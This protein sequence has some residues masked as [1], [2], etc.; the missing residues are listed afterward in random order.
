MIEKLL[1]GLSED[2]VTVLVNALAFEAD[3]ETPYTEGQV[4]PGAFFPEGGEEQEATF[5]YSDE[6]VYLKDENT[7]GFMKPYKGGRY[8][9]AALLPAEGTL[10]ADY[11]SSLTGEK[12]RALLAGSKQ[13]KVETV[14]PKFET[15]FSVQ[16]AEVL[17]SMGMTDAFDGLL[18]DF[19]SMGSCDDGNIFIS[20]VIH[21][22][23]LKLD[24]KG[25]RAGAAT[26][27][28][29]EAL[30]ALREPPPQVVLDRP[31]VYLLLDTETNIPLFIGT[32]DSID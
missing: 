30:T 5:L 11:V 31:L 26:A 12:L 9:F 20:Q 23:F 7:T 6:H 24:E 10:L 21:K 18:A 22:T 16:L 19:S 29:M 14:T 4:R 8:A 2:A 27:A 1:D 28:V 15:E 32:V 13:T 17:R 3:W 25:T